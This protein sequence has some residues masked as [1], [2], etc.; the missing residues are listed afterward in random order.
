[1]ATVG[2]VG[3]IEESNDDEGRGSLGVNESRCG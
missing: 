2:A 1:M 3:D